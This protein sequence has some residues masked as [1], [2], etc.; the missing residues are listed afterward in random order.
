MY[1]W[2]RNRR[3]RRRGGFT[4]VELLLVLA[5]IGVISAITV[6]SFV[7]SMKGNRLRSAGRSVVMAGRYARSM[8]L[9]NQREMAV[10]FDL[11]TARISVHQALAPGE[12]GPVPG[13]PATDAAPAPDGVPA[14]A[15]VIGAGGAEVERALDGVRIAS[16]H[17][18]DTGTALRD[19]TVFVV[20]YRSNGTCTPYTVRLVDDDDSALTVR[21]DMFSTAETERDG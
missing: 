7:R 3:T 10:R 4:L 17:V 12:A 21:V 18:T 20:W 9:L 15:T 8:A 6:P 14:P 13:A 16:V 2:R 1:I 19:P 11:A 5:I